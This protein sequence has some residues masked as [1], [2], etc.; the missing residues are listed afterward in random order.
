MIKLKLQYLNETKEEIVN[1][2]IFNDGTSQVW[3][4]KI[5]QESFSQVLTTTILWQYENEAELFHVAQL[6]NLI[7]SYKGYPQPYKVL[8]IPF[9][10]YGRQDKP[11][12]NNTTFA[13]YTF[14]SI[15]NSL[16]FDKVVSFDPHGHTNIE[17]FHRISANSIIEKVFVDGGYDVYAFPDGGACERYQHEPSVNGIK[18]RNQTTGEIIDYELVTDGIDL[19]GKKILVVDDLLDGGATFIKLAALLAPYKPSMMGLY[20]S[21]A[22]ASKGYEHLT[23]AG[24]SEFYTT[25]SLVKNKEGINIL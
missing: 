22:I 16:K 1:P 17:K 23:E 13:Q 3:K 11:I 10:P 20:T 19:E 25:N 4:V 6:S 5:L 14:G 24:Y 9:L 21:H 2:T 12:L 8:Y 7:D 15:I 18:Y